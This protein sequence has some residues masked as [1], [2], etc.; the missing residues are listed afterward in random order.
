MEISGVSYPSIGSVL[1]TLVQ[2][3]ATCNHATSIL[4]SKC[5]TSTIYD[6]S[7]YSEIAVE[8]VRAS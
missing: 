2:D 8:I 4:V 1:I 3:T 7:E 6:F 5:I